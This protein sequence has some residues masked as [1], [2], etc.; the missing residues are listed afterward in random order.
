[1]RC[2]GGGSSIYCGTRSEIPDNI[3]NLASNKVLKTAI[4]WR[5]RET[6]RISKWHSGRE[7]SVLI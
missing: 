4:Y 7:M 1:M 5:R 2:G 6:W 3:R